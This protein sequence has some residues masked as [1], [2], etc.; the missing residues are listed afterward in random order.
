MKKILLTLTAVAGITFASQAQTEAGKTMIGGGVSFE[1]QSVKDSDYK[2]NSF[3]ILPQVGFFVADN[4]AVGARLGYA[5]SEEKESSDDKYA[6]SEFVVAPF[7]RIYQGDGQVK[8]FG[9]LSAPMSWGTIKEDGDKTA[10]TAN[11]GVA[12]APGIAYFPTEKI[13]IELSVRGLYFESQTS[14]NEA[15]DAKTTVNNFGLNVNS[16]APTLGVQFHF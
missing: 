4:I 3:S 1:T 7:G 9:Q 2:N 16:L 11:Y 13:G 12:L 10:T 8:F 6:T 14:K 15:T 5:W